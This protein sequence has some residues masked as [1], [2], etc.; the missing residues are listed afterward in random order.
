MSHPNFRLR[1][2][3]ADMIRHMIGNNGRNTMIRTAYWGMLASI[4]V[5]LTFATGCSSSSATPPVTQ[6]TTMT[7]PATSVAGQ[8]GVVNSKYEVPLTVLVATNGVPVPGV[9]VVFSAP[10]TAGI[11][12]GVFSST[13]SNAMSVTTDSNG[14]ATSSV[15]VTPATTPPSLVNPF[16]AN[17]VAGAYI[18]IASTVGTTS[19]AQ[20]SMFNTL[21]PQGVAVGSGTPQSTS[22]GTQFSSQLS[23]TVTNGG[24]SV[25]V[26]LP[27][28]FTDA[29]SD[30]TFADSQTNTTVAITNASGV[31][32]AAPFI[33]GATPSGAGGQYTITATTIDGDNNTASFTLSNTL[34]PA[35]ITAAGSSTPQTAAVN[36]P[37]APL[38]VTLMDGSTPSVPVG[39]ALVTFSAPSSGASGTFATGG[40]TVSLW[41]DASGV[42]TAP[43][44]TANGSTGTYNV[45]ASVHV[46]V[47][48][49]PAVPSL[50]TNFALTNQ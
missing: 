30:G 9:T 43:I 50:S 33:A 22:V 17:G 15:Y 37:F 16:V 47:T 18:I 46:N 11:A 35:T 29:T 4:F 31:A 26:G 36:T 21:Q 10:S 13:S 39:G 2:R 12:T 44:F 23:V 40:T 8:N 42:A 20:F 27:V 14:L 25:G 38:T 45:S 3:S 5:A 24:S 19:T 32:T 49:P 7:I 1:T 6:I 34:V 41:T 28:T 48:G